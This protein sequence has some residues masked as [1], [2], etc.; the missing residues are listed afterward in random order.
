LCSFV[1]TMAV[2]R[3]Q[4]DP[5]EVA[6]HKKTVKTSSVAHDAANGCSFGLLANVVLWFG[7][8]IIFNITASMLLRHLPDAEDMTVLELTVVVLSG[9]LTLPPRGLRLL[10][11]GAAALPGSLAMGGFHL[12]NCRSFVYCLQF[13]PTSLAQTIRATNPVWVVAIT[14]VLGQRYGLPT[15]C[16]LIPLVGGFALAVGAEPNGFTRP[17]VAVNLLGKRRLAQ[18]QD[19]AEKTKPPHAFE[20]QFASSLFALVTLLP[21]WL[22]GGGLARLGGHIASA[23]DEVRNRILFLAATDGVL[24]FIEQSASFAALQSFRPLSFAVIDTLRR[25]CIVIVAGFWMQG[26]ALTVSRL[27]GV[28]LVLTGGLWFAYVRDQEDRCS[29]EQQEDVNKH[30]KRE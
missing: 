11:G 15:M 27:L 16:S 5:S 6:P 26:T 22:L 18:A 17:Q 7:S 9:I 4:I 21:I 29:L 30:T 23:T 2:D 19:C 8:S 20:L 28:L 10:P 13:I 14:G 1:C 12:C 25:L 24:Y 3:Q